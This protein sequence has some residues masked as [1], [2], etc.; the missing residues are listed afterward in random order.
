MPIK[1]T[2]NAQ[3]IIEIRQQKWQ[4]K[5]SMLIWTMV[6]LALGPWSLL[7]ANCFECTKLGIDLGIT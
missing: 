3:Q 4:P 7:R 5:G 6:S 1:S 2:N